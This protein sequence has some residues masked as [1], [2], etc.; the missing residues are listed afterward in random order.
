MEPLGRM[1]VIVGLA[2]AAVGALLWAGLGRDR[3]GLLPGDISLER[4]NVKFYFP[5]VTCVVLSLVLT[6]LI[7]L[8]RK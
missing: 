4:G 5:I 7:R 2:L 3:G 8:F 1:L 6:V